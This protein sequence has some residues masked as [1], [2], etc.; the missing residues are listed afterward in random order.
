MD[1]LYELYYNPKTGFTSARKLYL[2]LN[3]EVPM[4][5][6]KEFLERQQVNQLHKDSRQIPTFSP[7]VVYSVNDQWQI[8][9]ID[10]SKYSRW[11]TG[12]KYLLCGIDVFSRKS[13][14]VAMKRKSDTT[15]AM[16][17]ILDVQKPILIQSD[18]GTEF[19]NHSFQNLLQAKGVRHI[20][21]NVGDHN[22]QGLIER[23]NRTLDCL[24]SRIKE[25]KQ[26]H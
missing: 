5:Q 1:T 13:F 2:K 26:I 10:L 12:F 19:L 25:I 7:I 23:F 15:I 6:I 17:L 22:R 18:N 4:S 16:K 3:K 11:N 21:V 9:L 24:L 8:D 14:V 20:T